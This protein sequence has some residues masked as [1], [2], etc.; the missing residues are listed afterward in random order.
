MHKKELIISIGYCAIIQYCV[1]TR[2]LHAHAKRM[3]FLVKPTGEI[4]IIAKSREELFFSR[5][6]DEEI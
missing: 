4:K 6:H 1:F 5:V 2:S 3:D